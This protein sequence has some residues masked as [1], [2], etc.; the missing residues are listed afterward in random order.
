MHRKTGN[1]I[2]KY[3]KNRKDSEKSKKMTIAEYAEK[4]YNLSIDKADI[5]NAFLLRP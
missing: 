2:R 4:M 1:I 5:R 3:M